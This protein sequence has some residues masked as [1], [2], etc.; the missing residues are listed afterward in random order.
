MSKKLTLQDRYYIS[1]YS[2]RLQSTLKLRF[3]IDA[4]LQQIEFTHEETE[5]YEIGVDSNSYEFKCN[6]DSYTVKYDDFPSEVIEAIKNYISL[7]EHEQNKDNALL[8]K[9]LEYL[10]KV[11]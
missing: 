10:K 3:A 5:K 11:I 8:H 4:F 1:M 9:T 6:N 2:R 7:Y